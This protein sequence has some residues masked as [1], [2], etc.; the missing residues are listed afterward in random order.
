MPLIF[1][2]ALPFAIWIVNRLALP[3]G[4]YEM[5]AGGK[6]GRFYPLLILYSAFFYIVAGLSIYGAVFAWDFRLGWPPILFLLAAAYAILF[7]GVTVLFYE[8]YLTSK[9][10]APGKSNYTRTK[11][12]IVRS[13]GW[14]AVLLLFAATAWMVTVLPR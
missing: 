4:S 3:A 2:V 12:A 14:S 5:D 13:L 1:A 6:E 9:A 11:F 7:C 8:S 10:N